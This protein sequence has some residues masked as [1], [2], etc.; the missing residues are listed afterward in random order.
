MTEYDFQHFRTLDTEAAD[1]LFLDVFED[2]VLGTKGAPFVALALAQAY[3]TLVRLSSS[4]SIP[5]WLNSLF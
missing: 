5:L 1:L 2:G 3:D 4:F